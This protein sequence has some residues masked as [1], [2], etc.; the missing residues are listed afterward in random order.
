MRRRGA[1]PT[2]NYIDS[3]RLE[4]LDVPTRSFRNIYD[5]LDDLRIRRDFL[6]AGNLENL[7]SFLS[8]YSFALTVHGVGEDFALDPAGSFAN[9]LSWK[10]GAPLTLGWVSAVERLIQ[11]GESPVESFFRLLDA[12]REES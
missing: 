7:A 2:G 11:E 8:G 3:S 4:G 5:I 10:Y 12:F 1:Q 6:E 9:W